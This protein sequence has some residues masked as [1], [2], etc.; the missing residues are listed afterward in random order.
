MNNKIIYSNNLTKTIAAIKAAT[1]EKYRKKFVFIT[2]SGYFYIY[3]G[4]KYKTQEEAIKELKKQGYKKEDIRFVEQWGSGYLIHAAMFVTGDNNDWVDVVRL[5]TKRKLQELSLFELYRYGLSIVRIYKDYRFKRFTKTNSLADIS[6]DSFKVYPGNGENEAN[7]QDLTIGLCNHKSIYQSLPLGLNDIDSLYQ[8]S[9]KSYNDYK[10]KLSDKTIKMLKEVFDLGDS[11]IT[12]WQEFRDYIKTPRSNT[13]NKVSI[14]KKALL[15]GTFIP[16][17]NKIK[18]VERKLDEA[19]RRE[20]EQSGYSTYSA[21]YN[22]SAYFSSFHRIGDWVLYAGMGSKYLFFNVKSNKKYLV[23]YYKDSNDW[24]SSSNNIGVFNPDF[25]IEELSQYNHPVWYDKVDFYTRGVYGITGTKEVSVIDAKYGKCPLCFDENNKE[26]SPFEC[27]AGTIIPDFLEVEKDWL[28]KVRFGGNREQLVDVGTISDIVKLNRCPGLAFLVLCIPKN[29][30]AMV[31]QM[32]KLKLNGILL[33]LLNNPTSFRDKTAKDPDGY[34]TR[35][36]FCDFDPAGTNLKKMFNFPLDKLRIYDSTLL[37]A[38]EEKLDNGAREMGSIKRLQEFVGNSLTS[39]DNNTFKRYISYFKNNYNSMYNINTIRGLF[40]NKSPKDFIETLEK[41]GN[42]ST[43]T[44]Y[45][46]LRTQYLNYF[47]TN[48]R[49]RLEASYKV[50]PEKAKKF[51]YLRE[52]VEPWTNRIIIREQQLKKILEVYKH[53]IPVYQNGVILGVQLDLTSQEHTRFLHDE[54]YEFCNAYR[55]ELQ[56]KGFK[57]AATRLLKYEYKG[58]KLSI[59]APKESKDLAIEGSVLH[60]CVGGFVD[61]VIRGT[62]TVL[63]IRRNDNLN[64]PY[65]TIAVDPKGNIEQIHGYYNS[66]LTEAA[67]ENNYKESKYPVYDKTFD[68]VGFLKEWARNKK[69]IINGNSIKSQYGALG[70]H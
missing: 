7:P 9:D 2:S 1:S 45:I 12:K 38:F 61:S 39:M 66:S 70:A 56:A 36:S 44:D 53:A 10:R 33:S 35:N 34:W 27:F 55:S 20:A 46:R 68:L 43:Y 26:I 25:I 13:Y 30:T 5:S 40:P 14:T 21:Y 51:K 18:R 37:A 16:I 41:V 29:K 47:D 65:F 67:Q 4:G 17:I 60:H 23:N 57:N 54:L 8:L 22:N 50:L 6:E 52:T 19:E 49:V 3:N 64:H 42:L 48:E 24:R 59:V 62:E 58:Q 69:D 31:E 11:E 63:F 32:F 28:M 15:D